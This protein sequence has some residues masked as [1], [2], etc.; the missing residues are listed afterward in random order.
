MHQ[1]KAAAGSIKSASL[2]NGWIPPLYVLTPK[3]QEL[4]TKLLA[5]Q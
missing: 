4:V 3:G 5:F 2:P 1:F